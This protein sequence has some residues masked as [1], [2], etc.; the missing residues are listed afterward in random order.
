MK[1]ENAWRKA[2]FLRGEEKQSQ[3]EGVYRSSSLSLRIKHHLT[4]AEPYPY[5]IK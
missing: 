2:V 5:G 4:Y 1:P 3:T